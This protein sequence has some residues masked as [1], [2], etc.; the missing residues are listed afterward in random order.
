MS[1]KQICT[2]FCLTFLM[3]LADQALA[4]SSSLEL[5]SSTPM[6]GTVRDVIVND[7]IAYVAN[8]IGVHAFDVSNPADPVDL[9]YCVTPGQALELY[10]E[11]PWLYVA[12]GDSGVTILNAASLE[13]V[14][15]VKTK[16]R[17]VDIVERDDYLFVADSDSILAIIDI[18]VIDNPVYICCS[19]YHWTL[20]PGVSVEMGHPNQEYAFLAGCDAEGYCF[21][22]SFELLDMDNILPVSPGPP[23]FG[24]VHELDYMGEWY[25]AAAEGTAQTFIIDISDPFLPIN[26]ALYG[27][28]TETHNV[29]G[30]YFDPSVTLPGLRF[31]TAIGEMGIQEVYEQN[32]TAFDTPG[33]AY[34]LHIDGSYIF[35]ADSSALLILHT[36]LLS[37]EDHEY[38]S[39]A[40][41]PILRQNYP[42]PFNPTTTIRYEI[43]VSG[44]VGLRVYNT[45]GQLVRTLVDHEESPGFKSAQWDGRNDHGEPV[46]SGL[47]FY[48]L[49]TGDYQQTRRMLLLK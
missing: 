27:D 7:G 25:L 38:S 45:A 20:L 4:Q 17:A 2:Y 30:I 39:L 15:T 14:S 12:D 37:I 24:R 41:L 40:T 35:V 34:D 32:V 42:N 13:I 33:F 3:I 19:Q 21:I 44:H 5:V 43:P 11:M 31:Y 36:D 26:I 29:I 22:Y 10:L 28:P 49:E 16:D 8:G 47:Y 6:P 46:A 1:K 48:R 18:S 23:T 9:G